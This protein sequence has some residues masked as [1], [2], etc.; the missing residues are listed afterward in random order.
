MSRIAA[1]PPAFSDVKLTALALALGARLIRL[2]ADPFSGRLLF[3]LD[4]A[5]ADL[6]T[7][8]LNDEVTVSAKRFIVEM[9]N[10]LALVGQH[11]RARGTR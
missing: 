2:E 7:R 1:A 3:F 9:E 6:A 10:V 5:P 8:V 4:S 11:K